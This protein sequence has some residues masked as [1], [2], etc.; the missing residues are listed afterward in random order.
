MCGLLLL[1]GQVLPR[2]PGLS[3]GI[4]YASGQW[5]TQYLRKKLPNEADYPRKSWV[6]PAIICVAISALV[7]YSA[8][9]DKGLVE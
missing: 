9:Y 7:L 3:I 6:K 2:I 5:L 8:L 1:L 4:G